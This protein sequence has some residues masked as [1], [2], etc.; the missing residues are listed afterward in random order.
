MWPRELTTR[1]APC[2]LALVVGAAFAAGGIGDQEDDDRIPPQLSSTP[3]QSDFGVVATGSPEATRAASAVLE[4]GGNAVDAAVTAALA[5]GVA[6]FDAS[7][8]GGATNIVIR[9]ANGHVTAI[10]GTSSVPGSIDLEAFGRAKT[11][12]RRFGVEYIAVPTTLATLQLALDRYG[13]I[14]MAEALQPAISI[15]ERGFLLS[16]IQNVWTAYYHEDIIEASPFLR[17]FIM[18]DGINIGAAGELQCRPVLAQTLRR[19]A[20]EGVES[21]YRGSIADEIEREMIAHGGFL[22]KADLAGLLVREVNPLETTYRG[23]RVISFPAPGGGPTLI[24]GLDILE[25]FPID[26]LATDSVER[27]N[28]LVEALRLARASRVMAF[29]KKPQYGA[30]AGQITKKQASLL[31]QAIRPG[32]VITEESLTPKIDPKCLPSGESTTQVSVIDQWGNTVSMTQS[33]ARSFGTKFMTPEHGFPYNSFVEAFNATDPR[34]PGYLRPN[35]PCGTDMAPTIVVDEGRSVTALGTPGSMGIP[36]ILSIVISNLVDRELSP[37][38]AVNSPRVLWGG[39]E[40]LSAY[41]EVFGPI[42]EADAEQFAALGHTRVIPVRFPSDPVD[43][44]TGGGVNLAHH[45]LSSG[46]FTGVIDGRRGGL[47]LGPWV[48]IQPEPSPRN[49]Q[50]D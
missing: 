7:G 37:A 21:F 48:V 10:D 35:M 12:Q 20:R 16:E 36:S 3:F 31:A 27:L 50:S 19:L 44:A 24:A 39:S 6:D 18:T 11:A 28:V 45:D 15:A 8:I 29:F 1:T 32:S 9:L 38:D 5:L 13:T 23:R 26:F 47:A 4:R 42:S 33:L 30:R 25:A 43:M 14:S 34:C 41:L 46:R 22:R 2:L 17:F 49:L 40:E